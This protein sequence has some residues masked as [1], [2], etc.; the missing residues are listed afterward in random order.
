MGHLY[1]I[2]FHI[3][4][5]LIFRNFKTVQSL[6]THSSYATT[7]DDFD[8]FEFQDNPYDYEYIY[9]E[10]P[11]E[12]ETNLMD[13]QTGKMPQIS[14]L[15]NT[16]DTKYILRKILRKRRKSLASRSSSTQINGKNKRVVKSTAKNAVKKFLDDMKDQRNVAIFSNF[17]IQGSPNVTI[18]DHTK[19][20]SVEALNVNPHPEE[21]V[22]R[23]PRKIEGIRS[24]QKKFNELIDKKEDPNPIIKEKEK[25]S[26]EILPNL[27][28]PIQAGQDFTSMTIQ[29]IE[30]ILSEG[31]MQVSEENEAKKLQELLIDS[32][33][34][35]LKQWRPEHL[36]HNNLCQKTT[37]HI[38]DQKNV[39][40]NQQEKIKNTVSIENQT[41]TSFAKIEASM[42]NYETMEAPSEIM[43][44]TVVPEFKQNMDKFV[45]PL[46][47]P[48]RNGLASANL[49]ID[50]RWSAPYVTETF[51]N[52]WQPV[53]FPNRSANF[54]HQNIIWWPY[55]PNISQLK[56]KSMFSRLII[57]D[58]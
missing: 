57:E 29:I 58:L 7:F 14:A 16:K 12:M 21:N 50:S 8:Y 44:T 3:S 52:D 10:A 35:T 41:Y 54:P 30:P 37:I 49:R 51:K 19:S 11:N 31:F 13:L 27:P 56:D 53:D 25:N 20:L 39:T 38:E 43:K 40:E 45:K 1:I 48:L 34:L 32:I 28:D 2:I 17:P 42:K 18:E 15:Q 24:I 55:R 22:N 23:L 36:G 4:F 46:Y 47:S 6:T 9:E 33:C 5:S 26:I